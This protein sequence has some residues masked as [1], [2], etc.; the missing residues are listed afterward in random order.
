MD[1]G[2]IRK[3]LDA[4]AGLNFVQRIIAPDQFPVLPLGKGR[5]ATHKMSYAT[6]DGG[7]FVYPTV[8][9]D[10]KTGQLIPLDGKRAMRHAIETGEMIRFKDQSEA[11]W[12]SEHYKDYWNAK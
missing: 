1:K 9:Q 8:I 6:D 5:Y 2:Q 4:N 11:A 3:I 10:A 7:A 12:F